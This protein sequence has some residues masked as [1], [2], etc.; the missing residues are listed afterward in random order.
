MAEGV[1]R[2]TVSSSG[3]ARAAASLVGEVDSAGTGAYHLLEPPDARTMATLRKHGIRNYSHAARQVSDDD[4]VTFD[5][6]LAMDKNNLRDLL[7]MREDVIASLRSGNGKPGTG[8]SRRSKRAAGTGLRRAA[9]AAH[10]TVS[11]DEE[12]T[13]ATAK[14][15]E[16]RLF[17]DF[18]NEGVVHERVGGGE[19]V[20]DPYYG[21]ASGFEDVYQQAVRFSNNF[22]E[23]LGTK[24]A[25]EG[26]DD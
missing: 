10:A 5:Y 25:H 6:L 2:H 4:F 26:L 13:P 18:G 20:Q 3:T 9:A 19:V 16:V 17:G 22:L 23:Y 24:Q 8:A 14:V 15:A 12:T 21:G 11:E 7:E 1:F